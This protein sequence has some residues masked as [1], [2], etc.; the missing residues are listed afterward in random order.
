MSSNA[1][2]YKNGVKLKTIN[3][4]GYLGATPPEEAT[5]PPPRKP[6]PRIFLALTN[7]RKTLDPRLSLNTL[8]RVRK[9]TQILPGRFHGI[10]HLPDNITRQPNQKNLS[11][12]SG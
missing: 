8:P 7:V 11:A 1:I 9:H 3:S 6:R 5:P 10:L 4:V 2:C 12:N